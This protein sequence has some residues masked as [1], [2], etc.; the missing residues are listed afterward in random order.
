MS[1]LLVDEAISSDRSDYAASSAT[2]A[3]AKGLGRSGT[4]APMATTK[5]TRTAKPKAKWE[6]ALVPVHPNILGLL[7]RGDD[8]P[9]EDDPGLRPLNMMGEIGWEAVGF[10]PNPARPEEFFALLKR[11]RT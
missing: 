4:M 2:R 10:A 1:S 8:E 9:P 11:P 3:G 6:Y 7:K 5:R